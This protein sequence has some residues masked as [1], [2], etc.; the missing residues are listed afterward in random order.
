MGSSAGHHARRAGHLVACGTSAV[1]H[2][3]RGD[4]HRPASVAASL[5]PPD[6]A[7]DLARARLATVE[8]QHPAAGSPVRRG[9]ESRRRVPAAPDLAPLSDKNRV[10]RSPEPGP[11]PTNPLPN[12]RGNTPERVERVE[13]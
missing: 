7:A 1:D 8:P 11:T 12:S 3:P 4:D 2:R 9:S 5:P 6:P 13:T 10:A